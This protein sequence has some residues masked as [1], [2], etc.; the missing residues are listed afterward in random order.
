[1][2]Y[3]INPF[4][5]RMSERTSDQEFVRLF[6]PK[7]LEKLPEDAFDGLYVVS[8]PPGGGK[9][10]LLRAFTPAVLKA[11]WN[12]R[13]SSEMS[14]SYAK[15]Q[16]RGVVDD[17]V[18]PQLLGVMLSCA[19]GYADLPPGANFAQ[20]SI[21]RALLDCRIVLRTIRSL[22]ALL[23]QNQGEAYKEIEIC[24]DKSVEDLK[25][26]PLCSNVE[27]LV[28][29]AENRERTVYD[30]LDSIGAPI[31]NDVPTH[32]RFEGV[33]WLQGAKFVYK[34]KEIASSR[35][36]MIDDLHKLRAKQRETLITEIT[37]LRPKIPVWLAMRSVALGPQLLSQGAREGRDLRHLD[38]ETL[39]NNNYKTFVGYAQNIL[40]R[41]LS[42]QT[43]VPRGAFNQY[44]RFEHSDQELS[45]A[46]QKGIEKFLEKTEQYRDDQQ[47]CEWLN[48]AHSLTTIPTY[49]NL[50]ELISIY[51]LIARNEG[52]RQ[53]SLSLVPLSTDELE[54]RDSG[55][56]ES[57]AE[58]FAHEAFG[59][60]YYFGIDRICSLATNNVEEL[61]RIAAAIFDG[62]Q[63]NVV[64]RRPE[65]VLTPYE[66]EKLIKDVAKQKRNFIPK[67][68][69]QGK[70]AQILLDSIGAF[71]RDRTFIANAPYAPGVTGIRLSNTELHKLEM[72]RS[73]AAEQITLLRCVLSECVAENLL[74]LKQSAAS[75][76]RESGSIFYLNRLLCAHYGLPIQMGGWQ[77]IKA[78]DLL[79][80]MQGRPNSKLTLW[81]IS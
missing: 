1:M 22:H 32:V 72:A 81:E 60:P 13:K 54:D 48:K 10:T 63:A 6:S 34:G 12:A 28:K 62:L 40:D 74:C 44:L 80:W 7:I 9:T 68:H 43:I 42:A 38:L 23:G 37:E 36:L 35:L 45:S 70:R 47:Y 25:C 53:M 66:Q 11:F 78:E 57:A 24:Y 21:F 31:Y 27:D 2:A 76:A 52:K 56:I 64:L 30:E 73:T 18:G 46:I 61:L 19:S 59:V 71:C 14:E 39:W 41:R 26:I 58:I 8:S 33:L 16:S 5:E 79:G 51:I 15:L 75:T 55:S 69:T 17:T 67:S 65:P 4:L 29:W 3:R 77:D 20:E 50:L 49:D